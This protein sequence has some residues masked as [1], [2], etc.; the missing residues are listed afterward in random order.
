MWAS[1]SLCRYNGVKAYGHIHCEFWLCLQFSRDLSSHHSVQSFEYSFAMYRKCS[2]TYTH[3]TNSSGN[4]FQ[5]SYLV[6]LFFHFSTFFLTLFHSKK[7]FENNLKKI[8]SDLKCALE[9]NKLLIVN[10]QLFPRKWRLWLSLINVTFYAVI[11]PWHNLQYS[12]KWRCTSIEKIART[13]NF[14]EENSTSSLAEGLWRCKDA[15]IAR[16]LRIAA[17]VCDIAEE[18]FYASQMNELREQSWRR[19]HNPLRVAYGA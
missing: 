11:L 12:F 7:Q 5:L 10:F 3:S 14:P 16:T 18:N 9:S 2:V 13:E 8:N 1:C 17:V 4:D 19:R 6:T 15:V